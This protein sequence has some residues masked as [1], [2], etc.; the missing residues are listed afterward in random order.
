[1]ENVS[2]FQQFLEAG[3]DQRAEI[4][5]SLYAEKM[6]FK[7]P[8]NEALSREHFKRIDDDLYKQL[9][10]IQFMVEEAY[11]DESCGMVKWVMTY[12]FRGKSREIQGV[13]HIK[14]DESAQICFQRDYWDASFPVYG[15][16]PLIGLAMRGIRKLLRVS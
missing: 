10:E 13:S 1:M 2:R 8:M 15:E 14:F 7:D 11:G 4:V 5:E 3:S 6:D 12:R 16:F 9:K